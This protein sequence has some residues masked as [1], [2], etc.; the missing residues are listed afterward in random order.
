MNADLNELK[1][2]MKWFY[3]VIASPEMA[4][5]IAKMYRNIYKEL[6]EQGFTDNEAITLLSHMNF[7]KS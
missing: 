4:H 6:L 7:G 2:T 3:D 5:A 1:A